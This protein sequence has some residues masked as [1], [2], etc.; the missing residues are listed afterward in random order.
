MAERFWPNENPVGRQ[1][2]LT[3]PQYHGF[4]HHH[5]HHPQHPAFPGGSRGA[6]TAHAY[7]PY[8][9]APTPN[10]GL[11]IRVA[12]GEPAAITA[13]VRAEI[14]RLDSGIPLFN[15]QS[16]PEVKRLGSWQFA[17]FGWMFSAF[18]AVALLLA[19]TGVY[20]LLAYSVSQRTQEIGVRVA[21]GASR[22]DV[23]RLIVG[24][25]LRL[26]GGGIVLGLMGSF[27]VTRVVAVVALQHHAHRP[28]D[29][30]RCVDLSRRRGAVRELRADATCDCG[31]S[32]HRP[33]VGVTLTPGRQEPDVRALPGSVKPPGAIVQTRGSTPRAY[34]PIAQTCPSVRMNSSPSEMAGDAMITSPIV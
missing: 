21:L 13:A 10:A 27:G 33:P 24:Q 8:P 26:A 4:V 18:G 6:E 12:S 5:R 25:G 34:C 29:V 3:D 28:G 22:R 17:I 14:R 9:Y 15:I 32:A 7:V 20:G 2:R 16:M 1:F 31:R 23:S 30:C 19:V 11:T